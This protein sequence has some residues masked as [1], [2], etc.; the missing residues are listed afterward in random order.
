MYRDNFNNLLLRV[1]SLAGL[2]AVASGFTLFFYDFEKE[3]STQKL[4]TNM[5]TLK[6]SLAFGLVLSLAIACGPKTEETANPEDMEMHEGQEQTM[7]KI[8]ETS[9][10][11]RFENESTTEII[12]AYLDLK[13][14]LVA[15]DGEKAS[16]AA[17][18]LVAVLSKY[19]SE[20]NGSLK[21]EVQKIA[22]TSDPAAQRTA[23][24]LVS[25]QMLTLA[26]S[27]PLA[28]GKLYKQYCP[29]AKNNEGAFWLS[30]SDQIRNPYFGDKMLKCGSVEEEI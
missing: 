17:K 28:E 18:T 11:V 25:Q 8:G 16:E 26:K 20:A 4:I 24:D 12:H 30:A 13:D 2:A 3:K 23:F 1:F 9:S 29:M 15:T 6:S 21:S 10:S 27:T 7:E 14:Q 5:N 22:D 19:E